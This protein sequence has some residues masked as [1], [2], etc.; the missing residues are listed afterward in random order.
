MIALFALAAFFVA[1]IGTRMTL[2]P[3]F[4]W[5]FLDIPTG[6]SLHSQPV[7]RTGGL[8]IVSSILIWTPV[9]LLQGVH[10]SGLWW[11]PTTAAGVAAISFLDDRASVS[12]GVRLTVQFAVAATLVAN[13]FMLTQLQ[14]GG[15]EWQGPSWVMGGLSLLLLVWMTNLY[16]FMD[17]MDGFAAGMS[18]FGF[19]IFAVMGWN[20]GVTEF[21]VVNAI[22]AAS[23]GGFLI[24]NFPP[25][26]VFMGDTGSSTLGLLAGG[27]IIWGGNNE[28]FPVW[29]GIL[30]F[31][32]FIVDATVTVVRRLVQG[33]KIWLAHRSHYYQRLVQMGWGHKRTVIGEY[34]LMA[35][36]GASGYLAV[37]REPAA[38]WA[39][40][41]FWTFVYVIL[42]LLVGFLERRAERSSDITKA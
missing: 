12:V 11:L 23:A 5:R 27:L 36:S 20:V 9:A 17:G 1:L 14:I 8:A 3:A 15:L 2:M 16:N 41:I 7:P 13:G 24:F 19:G 25:A 6:R 31:S 4:S 26:R 32:P 22:I 37:G 38:Q 35:L 34:L 10:G 42:V 18:V 28:I 33:D 21:A 29:I 30:I 39:T 40:V